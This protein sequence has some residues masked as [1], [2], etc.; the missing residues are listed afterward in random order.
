MA[1]AESRSEKED[2]L[3]NKQT[4][5]TLANIDDELARMTVTSRVKD[6]EA[7][8]AYTMAHILNLG[9]KPKL[10]VLEDQGG[11]SVIDNPDY[12]NAMQKAEA[13]KGMTGDAAVV[14]LSTGGARF[15]L[16]PA[17]SQ[18][19][20]LKGGRS[21][22]TPAVNPLTAPVVTPQAQ[23]QTQIFTQPALTATQPAQSSFASNVNAVQA[24]DARNQEFRKMLA[25]L[26]PD[27]LEAIS[28]EARRIGMM[29]RALTDQMRPT[30]FTY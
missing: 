22:T 4:D 2:S 28:A 29:K 16:K 5:Y 6:A 25:P 20:T 24:T 19:P 23:A 30:P 13:L 8:K 18:I 17:A 26:H 1:R 10:T 3:W 14:P 7:S 12:Q 11:T 27:E 9:D 15:T 21:M